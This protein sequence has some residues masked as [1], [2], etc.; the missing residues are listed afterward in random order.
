MR[1]IASVVFAAGVGLTLG[2]GCKPACPEYWQAVC[3]T[4]G[5]PSGACARA[6][7]VGDTLKGKGGECSSAAAK[8]EEMAE[9]ESF[10]RRYC[11]M[12]DDTSKPDPESLQAGAW[13]CNGKRVSFGD[14]TV[15]FDDELHEW[16]NMTVASFRITSG[17]AYARRKDD[18]ALKCDYDLAVQSWS[19]TELGLGL[20]C[21][22]AVG[23]QSGSMPNVDLPSGWVACL[24]ERPP[25]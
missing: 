9:R 12:Y 23:L 13:I 5:D 22:A 7:E 15:K 25:G 2:F 11:N 4:C 20:N 10:A 6:K 8:F 3:R 24:R 21:P 14:F 1:K 19:G 18:G 16:S 17:P